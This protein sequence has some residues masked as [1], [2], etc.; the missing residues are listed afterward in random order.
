MS[1]HDYK[2]SLLQR[3]KQRQAKVAIIGLGYVGLPLV[4]AFARAGF[5]ILGFDV[6]SNK[7]SALKKGHSY[8]RHIPDETL[9][10]LVEEGRF[11][12]TD[13]FSRLG[14]PD[15]I[16]ICV[17]TPLTR[18]MEPNLSYIE[19]T[20]D[21]IAACFRPGQ[22]VVLESTTYPGT[23]SEVLRPILER[24][25][26]K[27]GE[28]SFLAYSPEREDP[29]NPDFSTSSIPKVVGA[30]DAISQ[31]IALALYDSAIERLVPV[32]SSATAEAV[33]LTEN[34]F[35]AVNIA[36]VNELKLI[37]EKW[38][39]ISGKSSKLPRPSPSATCRFILAQGWEGTA[40]PLIRFT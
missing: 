21:K 3:I 25:G 20:A 36:L 10:N 15:A 11:E 13:D 35:R 34:V 26:V 39:S 6:D 8:I 7:V 24:G 29:S 40:F 1:D 32:S 9:A 14:E 19:K 16:L 30:E 2:S 33:K 37:Y 5:G 38:A 18:H 22:I 28:E 17:P 27:I 23:T 4:L 31:Q 12:A